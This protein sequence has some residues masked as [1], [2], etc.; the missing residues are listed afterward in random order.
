M[1][2]EEE[3]WNQ[4]CVQGWMSL[5]HQGEAECDRPGMISFHLSISE[6]ESL[7]KAHVQQMGLIFQ[8][9]L[10]NEAL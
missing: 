8:P 9:L 2:L 7:Q 1:P 4:L 3:V 6:Q 10:M 5:R